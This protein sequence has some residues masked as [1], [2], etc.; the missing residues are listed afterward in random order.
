MFK[1]TNLFML[2]LEGGS[3]GGGGAGGG[4]GGEHM[5]EVRVEEEGACVVTQ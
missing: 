3:G 4:G 1:D 2:A 5:T